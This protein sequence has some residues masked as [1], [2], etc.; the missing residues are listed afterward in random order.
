MQRGIRDN[1]QNTKKRK[2][3]RKLNKRCDDNT[4]KKKEELYLIFF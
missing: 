3:K 1:Q 4:I 2:N